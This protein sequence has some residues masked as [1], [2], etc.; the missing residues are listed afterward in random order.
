[1]GSLPR[2]SFAARTRAAASPLLIR[3]VLRSRTRVEETESWSARAVSSTSPANRSCAAYTVRAMDSRSRPASRSSVCESCQSCAS[4][5]ERT[6][7]NTDAATASA[8]CRVLIGLSST[9]GR[10]NR[11]PT[12][13]PEKTLLTTVLALRTGN[14]CSGAE[15]HSERR[16]ASAVDHRKTQAP[17]DFATLLATSRRLRPS[18]NI[19]SG[20]RTVV[21]TVAKSRR[22]ADCRKA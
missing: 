4:R 22:A 7:D 20:R 3:R 2:R 16:K 9:P 5:S 19:G 18:L 13:R 6:P 10:Y 1:M 21:K 12:I 8:A 11:P 14:D 17:S 15:V